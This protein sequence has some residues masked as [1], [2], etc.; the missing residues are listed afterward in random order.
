MLVHVGHLTGEDEMRRAFG[1]LHTENHLP[2]GGA[3]VLA[4]GGP[5]R[6][7]WWPAAD[8]IEILLHRPRPLVLR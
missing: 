7:C 5:A 6:L 3:P 2:F 1:T 4:E 8:P